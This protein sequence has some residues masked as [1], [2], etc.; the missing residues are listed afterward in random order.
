[1]WQ[2]LFEFYGFGL[3]LLPS[4]V[5]KKSF[6]RGQFIAYNLGNPNLRP[7]STEELRQAEADVDTIIASSSG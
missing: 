1:M 5:V 3:V 7:P 2:N 6:Y 4:S